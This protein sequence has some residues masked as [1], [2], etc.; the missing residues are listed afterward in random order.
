[1]PLYSNNSFFSQST[2]SAFDGVHNPGV[3][4]PYSGIYRCPGCGREATS[5]YGNPLPS[6]NHHQHQY[7]QG[8][9]R[10]QLVAADKAA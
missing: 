3:S 1:M 10:W 7:S 4:T 6:Q 2:S 8:S 9:V 5:I